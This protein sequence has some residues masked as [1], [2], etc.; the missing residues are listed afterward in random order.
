MEDSNDKV[1]ISKQESVEN[2]LKLSTI[3][4]V[5]LEDFQ[6]IKGELEQER[7]REAARSS[8]KRRENLS[9]DGGDSQSSAKITA[10][11]SK[12]RQKKTKKPRKKTTGVGTLSFATATSEDDEEDDDEN[13]SVKAKSNKNPDVD[14]S[15][16]P[17]QEREAEEARMRE[18][19][20]LQ[21]EQEQDVIKQ[22]SILITYSYWDG[23]GHRKQTRC[24]KG[25]TIAQFLEKCQAQVPE[26]RGVRADSLVY[27]KEDLIIP[28]H[29]TFYDFIL[30]K[31]RGK[32]GPLFSFDVHNDVRLINDATREKD[33][34]HAGKV[35]EKT[36]YERNKHI[37]PANRWEVYDPEKEY[38][39][40]TIRGSS[41]GNK[42]KK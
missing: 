19:L 1:F 2:K 30:N 38:G 28:H 11:S 35:C 42:R 13:A 18:E 31:A 40:Y 33:D 25:D 3:G 22:E 16:L 14:T 21:W 12:K 29:Y 23:S 41:I 20:R 32:S 36:W 37:F 26:L 39:T 6:R 34:S 4:L 10:L 5:N 7:K 24:K 17:D 8:Q 27:I 15:F 9:S